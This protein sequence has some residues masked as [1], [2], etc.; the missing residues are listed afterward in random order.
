MTLLL[1]NAKI[2]DSNSKHDGKSMDIL[3]QNGI[4][5]K[6]AK[7]IQAPPQTKIV[8]E[9]GL[10]ISVGW[11][12]IGTQVCDP[13]LE[14]R[15]D[16]ESVTQ[17][18]MAGGYTVLACFPNTSPTLHNKSQ[19]QYIIKNT[20]GGMVDVF[21]IGAITKNCE[22]KDITEMYDMQSA[23]AVAFSDGAYPILDNG[24]MMRALQYVKPFDGVI[25]NSPQDK[26]T[27]HS[28]MMH[29]G[30]MSTSLGM[31]GIPALSEELMLVRDIYLSEYT[32]SRLHVHNVS[33]AKG[34][35]LIKEAKKKKLKV[36][37]SVAA[38][39]L[40]Y[41]DDALQEFDSNLKVLPPLREEKDRKA[42]IKGLQDGTIDCITTGHTPWHIEAKDLEFPYAEF[43]A[44]GLESTFG[45]LRKNL[46][47][48]LSDIIEK[49]STAP[50][51]VLGMNI[52]SITKGE[53]ANL[54]L[55]QP[56]KKWI[57]NLSDIQSKSKNTP[58]L[59]EEL[60]G[61][62]LAVLHGVGYTES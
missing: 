36:T 48:E 5:E 33:T 56:D 45:V 47:L 15:E 26:M 30:V 13:G 41:T 4:I 58:L 42:L 60:Q 59:G 11:M 61:K 44:I 34:V 27:S 28:G 62:V 25:I 43:G 9:K 37:A 23:G 29:E 50:R 19:I 1:K 20:K 2:I 3:I 52:P 46:P 38:L 57:F 10:H 39:N 55:F 35:R 8:K 22:G 31:K 17:A 14:H 16:L 53:P 24:M 18:A 21:P 7:K 49:I 54:T 51:R 40:I 32:D 6:I 12:D